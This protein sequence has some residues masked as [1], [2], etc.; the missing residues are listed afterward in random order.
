LFFSFTILGVAA[1]SGGFLR[2]FLF[3][4]SFVLIYTSERL[5]QDEP[6]QVCGAKLYESGSITK[7]QDFLSPKILLSAF[8]DQKD[9][10]VNFG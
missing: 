9:Y 7:D 6:I 2:G 8:I 5:V 3:S 10:K 1:H 4:C